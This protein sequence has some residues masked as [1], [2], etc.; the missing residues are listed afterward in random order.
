MMDSEWMRALESYNSPSAVPDDFAAYWRE[1]N[2][3]AKKTE[4]LRMEDLPFQNPKAHYSVVSFTG[5]DGA[6]LQA[7][8]L[9][10]RTAEP[11]PIVL[12][13]HDIGRG[14]RGW[15]YMA[16]FS[17]LGYAVFALENRSGCEEGADLFRQD[18]ALLCSDALCALHAA[19]SLSSTDASNL[20]TCGEGFGGGLAIVAAAMTERTVRCAALNPM[21]ADVPEPYRYV[22]LVHFAPLLKGRFLLGTGLLDSVAKP[23][24]QY[25]V[26][27]SAACPSEHHVYVRH[28]HERN[29]FFEDE[30]L[31]FFR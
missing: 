10:P 3:L 27:H 23:E 16:R 14:V 29:N 24:G 4:I 9:C 31:R 11:V 30:L 18:V 17:A 20:M 2:G 22:D 7:R 15:H 28:E 25:A 6:A 26:L 13:F 19:L 12:L 5:T 8:Y 21:P 1:R